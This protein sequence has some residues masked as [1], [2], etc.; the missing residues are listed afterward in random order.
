LKERYCAEKQVEKEAKVN[1]LA[2]L[3]KNHFL[4]KCLWLPSFYKKKNKAFFSIS[5]IAQ[6]R[7]KVGFW[8]ARTSP[9]GDGYA[10]ILDS[11]TPL[12]HRS[13]AFLK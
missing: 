6:R 9:S 1:F 13:L 2:F 8:A 4:V 10:I 11:P 7:R 5:R 3:L 12:F